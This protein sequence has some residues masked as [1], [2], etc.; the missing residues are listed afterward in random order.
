M[1]LSVPGDIGGLF[2]YNFTLLKVD[3]R[4]LSGTDIQFNFLKNKGDK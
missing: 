3:L 1:R 4:R 2:D